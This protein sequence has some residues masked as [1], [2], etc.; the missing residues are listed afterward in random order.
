[1]KN[2]MHPTDNWLIDWIIP[3]R[4][5]LHAGVL[6]LE[7]MHYKVP[8]PETLHISLWKRIIDMFLSSDE[9]VELTGRHRRDAQV[10]Q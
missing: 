6:A 4:M 10:T 3:I 9:I 2:R 8:D 7:S 5:L 1:M